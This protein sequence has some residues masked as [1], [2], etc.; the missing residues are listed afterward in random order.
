MD[1]T[2]SIL[3]TVHRVETASS[4]RCRNPLCENRFPQSGLAVN[5]RRFCSDTCKQQ[6]SL[7]RRAAVLL[8]VLSDAEVL[9]IVRDG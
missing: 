2:V 8:K 9:K 5:P 3:D 6:A 4:E 1:D 7:I